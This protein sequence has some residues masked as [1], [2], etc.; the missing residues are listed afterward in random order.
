MTARAAEATPADQWFLEQEDSRRDSAGSILESED[1]EH[2]SRFLRGEAVA[3]E[4]F[5]LWIKQAAGRY[6]VRLSAEWDDLL[7]DLLLEVTMALR[8]GAFR[9]DCQLQTFVWRIAHYRCL[10]RLRDLSRR[11]RSAH[12]ESA[13]QVPDPARPVLDRLMERE[14]TDLL[15]RF[16]ETMPA[17]CRRLWRSILAGRSYSEISGETGVSEGALRVR[18]LRCRRRAKALWKTWLEQSHGER[19]IS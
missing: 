8:E 13:Q 10:N 1:H 6:R 18:V 15:L 7:Q 12:E 5:S 17:R 4:K 16:L 11:P 2:I 19:R 9:G 3:V 14:S